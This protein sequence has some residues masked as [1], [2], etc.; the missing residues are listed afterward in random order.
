MRVMRVNV[1]KES[2]ASFFSSLRAASIGLSIGATIV[3]GLLTYNWLGQRFVS[4]PSQA[5][6]CYGLEHATYTP[7]RDATIPL[8]G[9]RARDGT[10]ID[11]RRDESYRLIE[12]ETT[13]KVTACSPEASKQYRSAWF[14][15]LS[16]RLR[17]TRRLDMEYGQLGLR[18]AAEIYSEPIDVQ[19]EKGLRDRYRAGVFRINDFTQNRDAVAILVLKGG[20]ALRPCR[21]ADVAS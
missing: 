10:S 11:Q 2:P 16:S 12:S 17:H 19:L 3:V 8:R 5:P 7:P 6:A 1:E 4:D 14:W 13:C 15:Y 9:A 18:R 21:K 20:A